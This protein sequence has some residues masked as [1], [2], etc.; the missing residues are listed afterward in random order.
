MIVR[1][2]F[3]EI[4]NESLSKKNIILKRFLK[5]SIINLFIIKFEIHFIKVIFKEYS[6]EV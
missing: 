3:I 4:N 1:F 5:I 6:R 2:N